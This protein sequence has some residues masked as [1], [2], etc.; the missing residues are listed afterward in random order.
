[1]KNS[2][3]KKSE[4]LSRMRW[5]YSSLVI[6]LLI[7][8][9]AY[10]SDEWE[11]A[12][13]EW[14]P[15]SSDSLLLLLTLICFI[16]FVR[17]AF[18]R[19][20]KPALVYAIIVFTSFFIAYVSIKIKPLE[21]TLKAYLF[22]SYPQ[23]CPYH[24]FHPQTGLSSYVCYQ[25]AIDTQACGQFER[26]IVNP[27]DELSRPPSQWPKEITMGTLGLNHSN[28]HDDE[29]FYRKTKL[30]TNHIYWISDDCSKCP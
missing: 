11:A 21:M 12:H 6:Y 13:G 25:Y 15:Y 24:H 1:M 29:C 22:S 20:F 14:G 5:A 8:V 10:L 3:D 18:K 4:T 26:L 17:M 27:G 28:L 7:R 19:A 9:L 16:A 2:S 30:I 23:L